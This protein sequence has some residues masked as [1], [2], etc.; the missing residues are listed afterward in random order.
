MRRAKRAVWVVAS[1]AI[2][3]IIGQFSG[4]R[5]YIGQ[6]RDGQGTGG[7]EPEAVT[8]MGVAA[9]PD[10]ALMQRLRAEA[11]R[12]RREPVDAKI[13]RVWKAIPGYNGLE[14]DLD[15]T[16][17]KAIKAPDRP[18]QYVYRQLAPKVHLNQLGNVPIYKGNPEKPMV[19]FMINVAWGNEY[20]VPILNTLDQ[21]KVKAT[22][23]LDGSWLKKN[24]ELAK[25]IQKRGHELS[26]HAYS[27]PDMS[28]LSRERATQEIQKTEVLLQE[29]LG[30]KNS[31]FAPPSGDF[32]QQTVDLAAELG[33]KT[34][35]WTL[36]TVD[37]RHPSPES[38]VNKISSQVESGSLILMHPTDSS[39]AALKGMI[40][41]IRS[42]GLVLGTVSQT[43]SPDRQLPAPVE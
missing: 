22:F 30:V 43:L 12:Q 21:E 1:L 20:I 27:H 15:A 36:D 18:I 6:L 37:W 3:L 39:A 2:T 10:N 4:V 38:V 25:E 35:L 13:D 11:A 9:L 7:N 16:Y 34:V 17:R 31:W 40:H 5:E 28:R 14:V 24:P 26:N 19:S 41:A 23:F 33:L 29:I 32:N 42:K 8:T